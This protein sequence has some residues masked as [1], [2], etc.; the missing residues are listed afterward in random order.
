MLDKGVHD[1]SRKNR[2]RAGVPGEGIILPKLKHPAQGLK[3]K[4]GS[5]TGL[6]HPS[7]NGYLE[8]IYDNLIF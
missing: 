2:V 6:V 4:T 1:N 7:G 3:W 8:W 5:L